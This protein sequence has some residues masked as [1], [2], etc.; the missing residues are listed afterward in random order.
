MKKGILI[1]SVILFSGVAEAQNQYRK[2]DEEGIANVVFANKSIEKGKEAQAGIKTSF[3]SD[4]AIY[5]R[6]YFPQQ[7]GKYNARSDEQFV[8]DVWVNGRFVERK[9]WTHPDAD[10]D[11]I[12]VY[13]AN[14]GDDDFKELSSK[15]QFLDEGENTLQISVGLER[16]MHT[17]DVIQDDGS[18]KKEDVFKLEIISK[19]KIV[20]SN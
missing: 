13:V 15:L 14:T 2:I 5:A 16:Y 6:C 20:I 7:F 19:G 8:V 17:K 4:E 12:L 3:K 11:Q 18:I 9:R 10:W 1:C